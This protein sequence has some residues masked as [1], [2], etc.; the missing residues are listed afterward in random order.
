[1]AYTRK[2]G[3]GYEICVSCGFTANGK[4]KQLYR[5]WTPDK[6]I[7]PQTSTDTSLTITKPAF[8]RRF[9]VFW[10]E[11]TPVSLDWQGLSIYSYVCKVMR[12]QSV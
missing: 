6:D 11:E 10:S 2:H 8:R 12:A 5:H 3:E 4:R 1:M 7:T 9:A